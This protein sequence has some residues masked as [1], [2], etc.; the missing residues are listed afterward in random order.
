MAFS[1]FPAS[2]DSPLSGGPHLLHPMKAFPLLLAIALPAAAEELQVV[3]RGPDHRVFQQ[4]A[5]SKDFL[6]N[7]VQVTNSVVELS[8]GMHFWDGNEFRVCEARFEAQDGK[9]VAQRTQHTVTLLQNIDQV[10]SVE[11]VTP[12]GRAFRTTP[13]FVALRDLDT[14]E[15]VPIAQLQASTAEILGEDQ[16][17][18]RNCM[19][20][21]SCTLRYSIGLN[22]FEQDLILH[23][24]IDP[25]LYEMEDKAS[26]RIELWTEVYDSG[27]LTSLAVNE[28][29]DNPDEIFSLGQMR[30][31]PGKA[32]ALDGS[33]EKIPVGKRYGRDVAMNRSFLV[34]TVTY[35]DLKPLL[36]Q[37]QEAKATKRSEKIKRMAKKSKSD[38][39]LLAQVSKPK[40]DRKNE[41]AQVERAQGGLD[42]GVVWD[43]QV[44]LGSTNSITLK[45]DRTYY[46]SGTYSISGLLTAEGGAVVKYAPTNNAKIVASGGVSWLGSPYRRITL[47]ARDDH[48]IGELIGSA[49]LTNYQAHTALEVDTTTGAGAVTIQNVS[50]RYAT[51]GIVLNGKMGHQISHAQFVNCKLGIRPINAEFSLK[52][53]LFANVITNFWGTGST[54]RL[55]HITVNGATVF[56]QNLTQL[57]VTNSLLVA[58]TTPGSYNQQNVQTAASAS[59]IFATVGSGS[60]YLSTDAYRGLGTTNVS[61]LADIKKLTTSAP[62]LWTAGFTTETR[63][64]P[65]ARRD[66]DLFPTLGYHY[67]PLDYC[68]SGQILSSTLILTNGVAVAA[69]GPDGVILENQ[70]RL[71][72]EGM[73]DRMNRLVRYSAIQEQPFRWGNA[74]NLNIISLGN[75]SVPGPEV[76]LR[77]TDVSLLGT[78]NAGT[79]HFIYGSL[80]KPW[81]LVVKDSFL[82]GVYGNYYNHV[83]SITQN[84]FFTN[85]TFILPNISIANWYPSTAYTVNVQ[86]RNN[87]IIGG[88]ISLTRSNTASATYEVRD[89]AFDT[90]TLSASASGIGNSKNGYKSTTV[91]GSS[92]GGDVPLS[93]VDYQT[94]ALGANYYPTAQTATNLAYL[95]NV[96]SAANA[97]TLG[98]YHFTCTTNQVKETNSIVDIGAHSIAWDLV[99]RQAID[100]DGDGVADYL[101]D[102]NGNGTADAGE[103]SWLVYNSPHGLLSPGVQIL[104]F[105]PLR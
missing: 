59:G 41:A 85:N 70:G 35:G 51:N 57:N 45:G 61:V 5:E 60:H 56:N 76:R 52:N 20:G 6:G 16:V 93:I 27:G 13:L 44:L 65:Q 77:F 31:G 96:G 66:V 4:V 36:D 2:L 90:V 33:G 9:V 91:L 103:N 74:G 100:S 28:A 72:S 86:L 73:P 18:Y 63:L 47:T 39:T 19:E 101:E 98:L 83:S 50:I 55:E 49:A 81:T 97:G 43:Y 105:T 84:Y 89:N 88:T 48:S 94:G 95:L 12:E 7:V 29:G 42:A 1:P 102:F 87:L 62:I 17:I 26:L 68:W 46:V 24:P 32:F 38:S 25:T 99:K 78:A 40:R 3:E 34:E 14:G 80:D 10:G 79:E 104:L 58:V 22:S 23:E 64:G 8:T 92:S 82:R 30:I 37:L 75:T 15:A 71:I 67:E 11:L 69:Y 21:L 53:A 54:G